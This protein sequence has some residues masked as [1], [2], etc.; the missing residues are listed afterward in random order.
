MVRAY[1]KKGTGVRAQQHEGD[2]DVEEQLGMIVGAQ[3][4]RRVPPSTGEDE[5]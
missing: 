3:I 2:T 4:W 1:L 5:K